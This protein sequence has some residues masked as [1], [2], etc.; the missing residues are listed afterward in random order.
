MNLKLDY[1]IEFMKKLITLICFSTLVLGLLRTDI[2]ASAEPF[3]SD[4]SSARLAATWPSCPTCD[5][6]R[7]VNASFEDSPARSSIPSTWVTAQNGN[8]SVEL[9]QNSGYAVCGDEGAT[10]QGDGYFYQDVVAVEGDVVTLKIFGAR[11]DANKGQKFEVQFLNSS[12]TVLTSANQYKADI[13]NIIDNT[14]TMKLYT[15]TT[16]AAPAGTA[17]VRVRGYMSGT[18]GWIKVDAACLTVLHCETCTNNLLLNSSFESGTTSWSTKKY[19]SNAVS[20]A[21]SDLYKICGSKGA[22]FNGNGYFYQEVATTPGKQVTLTIWGARHEF[23]NQ[24][25]QL[26]FM[27]GSTE[28]TTYTATATIDK[29]V[30]TAPWGLKKY[31]ITVPFS[32]EGTTKVSVRGA[33]TNDNAWIKVDQA[34]LQIVDPC[35]CDGNKLV[36]G[37]FESGAT[38]D[39]VKSPS[40]TTFTAQATTEGCGTKFGLITNVGGLYQAF[41]VKKGSKVDLIIYGATNDASKDQKFKLT[42][43]N[44]GGTALGT[45]NASV[46]VDAVFSDVLTKYTLSATAPDGAAKVRLEL[47]NATGTSS[48]KLYIDAACLKIATDGPL[49]VTLTNFA[50]TR[51]KTSALLTWSTTDETNSQEFE[52]Q[53]SENGKGWNKVGSVAAKGESSA[54]SNYSFVHNEPANG[55]NFYR[56]KMIDAD[57]TFAFSRILTINFEL[58]DAVQVYP[59]PTSDFMKLTLGSEKIVKVQMYNAMGVMVLETKPDSSDL[60]NLAHLKPGSYVVRIK[61]SS[62]ITSTRRIQVIK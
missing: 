49:P 44:S 60:I 23:Y 18:G 4:P 28:L 42:F 24:Q 22:T 2:K 12:G 62:G 35:G 7:L 46:D 32:P 16:G 10:F 59:N 47:V 38:T 45:G 26:V 11:H 54:L 41:D 6:N 20:L 40:G 57:N 43:Y 37:S 34:C 55:S 9:L 58:S 29:D 56:L 39:W 53:Q 33:Q 1:V 3:Q 27:N 14:N 25:F 17:K 48:T 51:E 30:D 19:G 15:I 31:S 8:T 5:D 13:D 52:I 50:V 61:Q 21:S 36:N